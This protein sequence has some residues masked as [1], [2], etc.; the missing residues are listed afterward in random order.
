[1]PI[2]VNPVKCPACGAQLN[3]EEGRKKVFCEYCGTQLLLNNENE[4]IFR[5]IDDADIKKAETDRVVKLEQIRIAE[6]RRKSRERILALK[7]I[8]SLLL[9]AVGGVCMS[10]GDEGLESVGAIALMA[11]LYI[12]M[13]GDGF[14]GSNHSKEEIDIGMLRLPGGVRDYEGKNY[15]TIQTVFNSAGFNNVKCIPLNDLTTGLIK[16]PGMVES[17]VINGDPVENAKNKYPPEALI[18]VSYHSFPE[19]T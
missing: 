11:I 1:M 2:S 9:G 14:L 8:I 19:R 12:W 18:V 3:I 17:I 15:I 7:I 4:Y 5:T 16:K 6:L 13:L 10:G